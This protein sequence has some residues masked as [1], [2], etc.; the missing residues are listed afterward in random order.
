[1]LCAK[2]TN[3]NTNTDTNTNTNTNTDTNINTNTDTNTTTNTRSQVEPEAR[4]IGFRR[5]AE[6]KVLNMRRR[7]AESKTKSSRKGQDRQTQLLLGSK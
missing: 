3:T 2:D 7:P 4:G 1:M 6:H 5:Q